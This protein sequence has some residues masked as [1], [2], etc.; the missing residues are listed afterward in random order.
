MRRPA[1]GYL[2]TRAAVVAAELFLRGGVLSCYQFAG[3]GCAII[4]PA[5]CGAR[6]RWLCHQFA[7]AHGPPGG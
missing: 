1:R 4:N 5:S 7:A 6:F 2:C 3:A